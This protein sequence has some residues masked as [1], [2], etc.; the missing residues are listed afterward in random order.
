M[1]YLIALLAI[2]APAFADSRG[3]YGTG[4]DSV[5][6][7]THL[8]ASHNDLTFDA[9]RPSTGTNRTGVGAEADP[10]GDGKDILNSGVFTLDG[11]EYKWSNGK[12]KKKGKNGKWKIL[13]KKKEPKPKTSNSQRGTF[14]MLRL[15]ADEPAPSDGVLWGDDFRVY[16]L[17]ATQ[18]APVGGMFSEGEEVVSLPQ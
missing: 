9:R 17:Q 13:K 16:T 11:E 15:E 18:R 4:D 5:V 8:S 10:S 7:A 1:K 2:A 3:T 14:G 6:I 12:L